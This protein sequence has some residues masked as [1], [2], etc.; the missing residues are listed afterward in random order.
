MING[1]LESEA[2]YL[3]DELNGYFKLFDET[4]RLE[5]KNIYDHDMLVGLVI[6]DTLGKI[7]DSLNFPQGNGKY[8][9]ADRF[10]KNA[11]ELETDI[12]Y[13]ALQGPF[14]SS[15]FNGKIFESGTFKEGRRNGLSTYYFPDG[16]IK[17]KC[18][19]VNGIVEGVREYFDKT[20]NLLYSETYKQGV[21]NGPSKSFCAGILRIT[22][23]YKNGERQGDQVYYGEDNKV[24]VIIKFDEGNAYGYTYMG[25][26]GQMVPLVPLK[27]G[28]GQILAYYGN[29]K[30]SA[31]MNVLNGELEGSQKIYYSNGQLAEEKAY[32]NYLIDGQFLR[33]NPEGKVVNKETY[34]NG[35]QTGTGYIY[36]KIGELLITEPYFMC[37]DHGNA[38]VKDPNSNKTRTYKYYCGKLLNIID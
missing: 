19:F 13:G 4:G 34:L 3:N 14:S 29:G 11:V 27:N 9:L 23:N 6:Y 36:D 5:K 12:K 32:K 20:G 30:R 7:I 8:R 24:A 28:T 1:S 33:Y 26:D 17:S 37:E 2:Y 18:E 22:Y 38:L 35:L 10:R 21:N 31:E 16:K 15:Y 25:K